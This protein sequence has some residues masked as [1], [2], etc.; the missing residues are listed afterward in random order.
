LASHKKKKKL[1]SQQNLKNIMR[2]NL[3]TGE[4]SQ[5]QSTS[6]MLKINCC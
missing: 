3:V 2:V 5:K 1:G 4:L 6:D